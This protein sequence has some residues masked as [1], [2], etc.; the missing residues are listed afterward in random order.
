MALTTPILNNVTA[1]DA[2]KPYT[3]T[4][5]V[6]GGDKVYA[7]RLTVE[8]ADTAQVVYQETIYSTTYQHTL[9]GGTLDNGTKYIAW[10]QTMGSDYQ[11]YSSMSANIGFACVLTPGFA[12]TNIEENQTLN[13]QSYLFNVKYT[14]SEL[15][16]LSSYQFF[17][18]QNGNVINQSPIIYNSSVG[19]S[20][21]FGYEFQGLENNK[22][23]S[24]KCTGRT[25]RE[26]ALDTGLIDFSVIA[27]EIDTYDN[28][29]LE[30]QC[31]L[32]RVKITT[33]FS[34]VRGE[35]HNGNWSVIGQVGLANYTGSSVIIDEGVSIPNE[36]TIRIW[37]NGF[38][39]GRSLDNYEKNSNLTVFYKP[40]SRPANA[41]ERGVIRVFY[42][43][44]TT[45][46]LAW[47]EVK[48]E[49]NTIIHQT[50]LSN[51]LPINSFS[52]DE[53]FIWIRLKDGLFDVKLENGMNL[54]SFYIVVDADSNKVQFN[55]VQGQRWEG[56]LNSSYNQMAE[57]GF[58]E[59]LK[60]D[61]SGVVR[62]YD[63]QGAISGHNFE[64]SSGNLLYG[65]NRIVAGAEYHIAE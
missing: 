6:V 10:V 53:I 13:T 60:V 33:N 25:K 62:V 40:S 32:G 41:N 3:F 24:V 59:T 19:T 2:V 50:A 39:D 28:L 15:E 20:I 9:P 43:E 45:Q 55:A 22:S 31:E 35:V 38:I 14:S 52:S 5:S 8:R 47:V 16:V 58:F 42:R 17:L 12:F 54:I 30:N 57:K 34:L 56:W 27:A 46:G 37:G 61:S 7:N 21:E 36:F 63:S 26:I 23:Y 11:V 64:D 44:D 51:F 65:S 1:F 18:Y 48:A 4:F 49:I 29:H